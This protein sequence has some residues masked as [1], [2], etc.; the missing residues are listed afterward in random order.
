MARL[1]ATRSAFAGRRRLVLVF[2]QRRYAGRHRSGSL[3][4]PRQPHSR[5]QDAHRLVLEAATEHGHR[6]RRTRATGFVSSR[7]GSTKHD[8]RWRPPRRWRRRAARSMSSPR[9]RRRPRASGRAGGCDRDAEDRGQRKQ[10]GVIEEQFGDGPTDPKASAALS[11]V[12]ASRNGPSLLATAS[13]HRCAD[14]RSSGSGLRGDLPFFVAGRG[15][16]GAWTGR[17]SSSMVMTGC[18]CGCR[19]G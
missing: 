6:P 7:G 19:E 16:T 9:N 5:D 3:L 11:A 8:G 15:V 13:R 2:P 1:S 17:V 18:P 10:S 4:Q 12:F 14:F